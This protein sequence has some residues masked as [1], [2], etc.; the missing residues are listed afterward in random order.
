MRFSLGWCKSLGFILFPNHRDFID[1]LSLTH[2]LTHHVF[3]GVT[4]L[5]P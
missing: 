1:F 5:L 3:K 2:S 4:S